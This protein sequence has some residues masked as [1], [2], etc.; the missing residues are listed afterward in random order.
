MWA[1]VGWMKV[2]LC[3]SSL[4]TRL[5]CDLSWTEAW[6]RTVSCMIRSMENHWRNVSCVVLSRCVW[7]VKNWVRCYA[8]ILWS[9]WIVVEMFVVFIFCEDVDMKFYLLSRIELEDQSLCVFREGFWE[10][11]VVSRSR[12]KRC[13]RRSEWPSDR[14]FCCIWVGRHSRFVVMCTTR[15]VKSISGEWCTN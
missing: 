6:C 11:C 8:V 12:L 14:S 13:T 10:Y 3:G 7:T 4:K 1:S 9:A 15:S 2:P 5:A